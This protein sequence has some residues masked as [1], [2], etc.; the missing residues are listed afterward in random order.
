LTAWRVQQRVNRVGSTTPLACPHDR[1][2]LRAA[3][4]EH[5]C[6]PERRQ[7]RAQLLRLRTVPLIVRNRMVKADA[8]KWWRIIKELGIK[9]E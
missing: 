5:N 9:A 4:V 6:K 7:K 1:F 2:Y 8:E 3:E